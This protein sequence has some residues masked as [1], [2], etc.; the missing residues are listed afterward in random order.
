MSLLL[1][2]HHCC[3][4]HGHH[5]EGCDDNRDGD[6]VVMENVMMMD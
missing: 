5:G 6:T 4:C 3:G 1:Q 2:D